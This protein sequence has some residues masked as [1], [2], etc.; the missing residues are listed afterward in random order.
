MNKTVTNIFNKLKSP[1]I[2]ITVGILGIALI[3][4]SSF[5]EGDSFK[6][7]TTSKEI[8]TEKYR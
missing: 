8:D 2:L 4:I 6:K 7:T 1:K 5:F 3:F